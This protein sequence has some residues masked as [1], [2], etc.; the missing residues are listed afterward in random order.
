MSGT[1]ILELGGTWNDINYRIESQYHGYDWRYEGN[2]VT[3]DAAF[4]RAEQI[5]RDTERP[6]RVIKLKED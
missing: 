3:K 6:V 2:F 4:A 5:N 1:V